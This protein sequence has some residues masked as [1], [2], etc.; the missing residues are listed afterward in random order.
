MS[1][2]CEPPRYPTL[3]DETWDCPE[4][5]G[6]YT[7]FDPIHYPPW[8]REHATGLGWLYTPEDL[9]MYRDAK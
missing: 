6:H 1:H 9:S 8:L 7:A 4:C 3:L 5:G 2:H